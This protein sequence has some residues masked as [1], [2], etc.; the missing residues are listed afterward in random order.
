MLIGDWRGN[1]ILYIIETIFTSD[2]IKKSG[3][4][5]YKQLSWFIP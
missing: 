4:T 1:F 5:C 2:C 3:V